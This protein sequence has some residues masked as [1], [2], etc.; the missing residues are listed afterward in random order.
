MSVGKMNRRF[1]MKTIIAITV[2]LSASSSFAQYQETTTQFGNIGY[3]NIN[4]PSGYNANVNTMQ[5]GNMAISNGYDNQG[6]TAHCTTTTFG[7]ITTTNC[8]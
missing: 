8:Y 5:V 4:G 3:T 7:N 2:I 6:H 1:I